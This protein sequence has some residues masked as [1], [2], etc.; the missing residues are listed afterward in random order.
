M[1]SSLIESTS[2]LL[3]IAILLPEFPDVGWRWRVQQ[4]A[5]ALM[6]EGAPD[7]TPI[8]I[9]IGLP[10]LPENEWRRQEAEIRSG[11][12]GVVVRHLGW[13]RVE[14]DLA[15]RM[16][17]KCTADVDGI[18]GLVL[19]RD[20]G[21]NFVD[22]DAW[23][24]CADPA[25]GAILPL[26]PTAYFVRDLAARY[27][28]EAFAG[29][30]HGPYWERQTHAFRM[31]RQSPCVFTTNAATVPDI[32]SYAGVRR[33]RI[34][35]SSQLQPSPVV[36][37]LRSDDRTL[38][39]IA[40]P[41]ARHDLTSALEGLR[42]FQAEG[43]NLNIIVAGE[44]AYGFDPVEG[45]AALAS[46]PT[47]S[48]RSTLNMQFETVAGEGDMRRLLKRSGMIWS[49]ALADGD[50]E[51][52]LRAKQAGVSFVGLRY[53]QNETLAKTLGVP[54]I[55]YDRPEAGAIADALNQ[56]ANAWGTMKPSHGSVGEPKAWSRVIE[57]IWSEARD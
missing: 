56:A 17:P 19:P 36:Q 50:N 8:E 52:L 5:V 18:P 1:P 10:R 35:V 48:R 24:V 16:Y 13:E 6:K 14:T 25:A 23:I 51:G 33:D 37:P 49:S 47:R 11:A 20:W 42:L 46:V 57:R 44:A 40:E 41:D 43:G 3:K 26:K 30:L 15:L 34:V 45:Q 31:W 53:P 7:G 54:A 9:A 4:L 28:P 29:G 2:V 12:P 22:C 27:V 21:W 55:F 38:L 39:W 32:S